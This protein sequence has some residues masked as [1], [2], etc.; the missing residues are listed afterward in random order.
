MWLK[1]TKKG[2]VRIVEVT[3]EDD[4]NEAMRIY[5]KA[6]EQGK[7]NATLRSMNVGFPPP[8]KYRPYEKTVMV[9]KKVLRKGKRVTRKVK[10]TV[11]VTPMRKLNRLGWTWCPYCREFRKF[12]DQTG[13]VFEGIYVPDEGDYC[14]MCGIPEDNWHVRKWNPLYARKYLEKEASRGARRRSRRTRRS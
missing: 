5:M 4:L 8:E 14:P 7:P 10:T 6:K 9:K 2:K 12:E 3:C 1:K 13:F 11:L